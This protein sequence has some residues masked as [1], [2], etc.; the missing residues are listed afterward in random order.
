MGLL[1]AGTVNKV[2]NGHWYWVRRFDVFTPVFI[3]SDELVMLQG[4]ELS[5]EEFDKEGLWMQ[6]AIMPNYLLIGDANPE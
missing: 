6:K 5:R 2:E 3:I 4:E 1:K